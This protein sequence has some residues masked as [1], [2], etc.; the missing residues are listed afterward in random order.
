[1]ST[2]NDFRA[3]P[4]ST[5][6]FRLRFLVLRRQLRSGRR[7]G[8]AP[9][10]DRGLPSVESRIGEAPGRELDPLSL[11][12][13]VAV[14]LPPSPRRSSPPPP[15]A[16]PRPSPGA[17]PRAGDAPGRRRV[18]GRARSPAG[19]GGAGPYAPTPQPRH[20]VSP[21]VVR[22]GGHVVLVGR[23]GAAV[24]LDAQHLLAPRHALPRP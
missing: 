12:R 4:R 13:L 24:L 16:R 9:A 22:R 2:A 3:A 14:P 20:D 1:M 7:T 10:N 5:D 18:P 19:P 11:D 15:A 23:R 17:P 21:R 6:R 8:A